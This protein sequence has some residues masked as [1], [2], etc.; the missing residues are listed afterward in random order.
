M[1]DCWAELEK[2]QSQ[3]PSSPQVAW[4][5]GGPIWEAFPFSSGYSFVQS[6]SKTEGKGEGA[7]LYRIL[8]GSQRNDYNKRKEKYIF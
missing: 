7:D 3:D 5:S 6:Y 8:Q 2:N 4:G 1:T